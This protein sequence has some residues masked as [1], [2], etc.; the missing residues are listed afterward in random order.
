MKRYNPI[1]L[2]MEDVS[3]FLNDARKIACLSDEV[4]ANTTQKEL[5]DS[6]KYYLD[7]YNGYENIF[8]DA[9]RDSDPS[10]RRDARKEMQQL[11]KYIEKYR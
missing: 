3:N 2:M 4:N 11:K 6:A 5:V 10:I 1:T 8:G 7:Q 9:L